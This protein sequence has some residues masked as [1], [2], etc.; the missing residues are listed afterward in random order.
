MNSTN[1]REALGKILRRT[2][3]KPVTPTKDLKEQRTAK[4]ERILTD[5]FIVRKKKERRMDEG[6]Q[7]RRRKSVEK[8]DKFL[9]SLER[10]EYYEK[11]DDGRVTS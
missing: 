9:A 10:K 11:K 8:V 4:E 3:L 6:F 7:K 1:K 5:F 2:D